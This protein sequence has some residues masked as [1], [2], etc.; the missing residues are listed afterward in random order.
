MSIALSLPA[1]V[2]GDRTQRRYRMLVACLACAIYAYLIIPSLVV[3]PMSFGGAGAMEFP[4]RHF[5]LYLY[6]EFFTT[7]TWVHPTLQSL[8]VAALTAVASLLVAAPAAFA[9]V[10]FEFTGKRIISAFVMS[11]AFVPTIVLALG[12]YLYFSILHVIGS[13][14]SLVVAHTVYV[15]P[16]AIVTLAAGIKQLDPSVETAAVLMGAGRTRVL[17]QVVLPQLIASLV[18]AALF[19]F[20]ISFDEVV[21]AY[22][23]T[24]PQ[25]ATLPVRMYSSIEWG[26]SPVIAAISTLL[27]LLSSAVCLLAVAVQPSTPRV[28]RKL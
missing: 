27:T 10:R 16:F 11:P 5:S 12:M 26:I 19:A 6:R 23:L 2:G 13:T 1:A 25:T 18:A 9:I 3:I 17:A 7:A 24:A 21:L 28:L 14:A 15:T 22:F 8:L 4:P 20:L